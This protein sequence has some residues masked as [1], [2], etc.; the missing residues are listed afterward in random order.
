MGHDWMEA[1]TD[2]PKTCRRCERTEGDRLIDPRFNAEA[3]Q[4]LIGIWDGIVVLKDEE[5][6]IEGFSG[7]LELSYTLVFRADGSYREV[8]GIAN[9]PVFLDALARL[10]R[11]ALYAEFKKQGLDSREANSAMYAAYGMTVLEYAEKMAESSDWN[12]V[13]GSTFDGV[14]YVVGNLI[15]TGERWSAVTESDSFSIKDNTLTI[16]GLKNSLPNLTITRVS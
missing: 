1:T 11:D 9:K 2:A 10:Y 13:Y 4:E 15:Y 5:T 8:I 12:K 14:Y 6:G 16:Q 7:R 3:C